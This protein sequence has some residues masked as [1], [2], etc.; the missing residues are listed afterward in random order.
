MVI[1]LCVVAVGYFIFFLQIEL[2][3]LNSQ[4]DIDKQANEQL[5][6]RLTLLDRQTYREDLSCINLLITGFLP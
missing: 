5:D 1:S 2:G 4:S 3:M 6:K